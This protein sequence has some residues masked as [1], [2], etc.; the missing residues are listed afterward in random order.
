MADT[1]FLE[2]SAFLG[3]NLITIY[4]IYGLSFF[5]IASAILLGFKSLKSIGLSKAFLY[6][7]AFSIVHGSVE[8]ID[9]YN[10]YKMLLYNSGI[11]QVLTQLRL[12]MLSISFS[13]LFLFGRELLAGIRLKPSGIKINRFFP[14]LAV[15]FIVILTAL[16]GLAKTNAEMDIWVRYLLGFP[17]TILAGVALFRLSRQEYAG[18]LPED[19]SLYF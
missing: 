13:L 1:F 15:L 16:G 12:Y 7:F 5:L 11:S 6:L 8:W 17:S 3:K 14:P 19:Y 4:F 9:M 18:I 10:R 2:L